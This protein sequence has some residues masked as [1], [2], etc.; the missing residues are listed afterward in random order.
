M[1]AKKDDYA[2]CKECDGYVLKK[3]LR[4]EEDIFTDKPITKCPEGHV[5]ELEEKKA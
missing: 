5:V 2:F 1:P 3:H 4:T